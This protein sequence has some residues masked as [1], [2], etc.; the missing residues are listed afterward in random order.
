MIEKHESLRVA[1]KVMQEVRG[2]LPPARVYQK[3]WSNGREQGFHLS[4]CTPGGFRTDPAVVFAQARGSEQIMVVAGVGAEDFDYQTNQPTE[5]AYLA[6][7]TYF[8]AGAYKKAAQFIVKHL[9]P[10]EPKSKSEAKVPK[11]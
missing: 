4:V 7:R 2:L 9:F 8:E 1:E 5:K 6:G 11:N 3:V 10:K